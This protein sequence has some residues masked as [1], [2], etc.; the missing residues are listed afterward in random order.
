MVSKLPP[1]FLERMIRAMDKTVKGTHAQF[2]RQ[3]PR[4]INEPICILVTGDDELVKSGVAHCMRWD[5]STD[6]AALAR[7]NWYVQK[8]VDERGQY[9]I[10]VI[11][12]ACKCNSLC[13][14][15]PSPYS[16]ST[17]SR[18]DY[19]AHPVTVNARKDHQPKSTINTA[20]RMYTYTQKR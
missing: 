7:Q 20:I 18:A 4:Y 5:H 14:F 13:L 9:D 12:T 11:P 8:V 2:L 10:K 19:S 1:Q 6:R 15:E 16:S 17:T 3:D